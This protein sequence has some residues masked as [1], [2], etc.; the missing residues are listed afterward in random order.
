M[1]QYTKP[2]FTSVWAETGSK[3]EP[4][5]AKI[6]QGWIVE[7]PPHEMMNWL[8]NR[9]DHF[10]AHIN[11]VGIPQWDANTEYQAQKS[12]VQGTSGIVYRA[13]QTHTNRNPD[14]DVNGFW[15]VAFES[16]GLSLLKSQNL[17]DVPDKPLARQNLGIASTEDYDARYLRLSQNLSDVPNKASAR[18]NLQVYGTT[19]VYT[20]N[21]VLSLFPVGKV[22]YFAGVTVP[23]GYLIA[24]GQAVSRTTYARLFTYIGTRYGSGDGSTTFNL[25]DLRGEFPRG[26]DLGRGVDLSRQVGSFQNHSMQNHNH[27]LPTTSGEQGGVRWPA[28]PDIVWETSQVNYS[29]VSG[30]ASTTYP[31]NNYQNGTQIGEIGNFSAETRPRNVALLPCISTGV[32]S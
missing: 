6:N 28:I 31:N 25:P 3:T 20:K 1:P 19:E 16:A 4:T 2:S 30:K 27:Y 21:E 8:Q 10:L 14:T 9:Q 12:Y 22:D 32:F 23:S 15:S 5:T 18:S 13:L 26:A 24:N 29:P 17:S 11:Q 7:I